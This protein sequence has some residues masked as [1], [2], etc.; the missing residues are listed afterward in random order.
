MNQPTNDILIDY[1][2]RQLSPEETSRI[3]NLIQQ[4]TLVAGEMAYL[5]LAIDTVRLNA[6]Q[7]KVSAVRRS[8][9]SV[10][11]GQKLPEQAIVR[12][13]Y[14]TGLRVA[15]IFVLLLGTAALYKYVSVTNQSVFNKQFTSYELGN[16]RGAETRDAEEEAYRNKDWNEVIAIFN[17]DN[18]KSDKSRFLA[19][20]AEMQL[21]HFAEAEVL[22][23]NLLN[24]PS[25][26]NSFREESEYYISLAY[27][28]DHKEQKAVG[29]LN[30]I[31]ADTSHTYYPLVSK[32]SGI[33]LKII[34][35]KH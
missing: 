1:L 26:D 4:D 6:I 22:F 14:K 12:N 29:M 9:K 19:A 10:Q 32:I 28:M 21:T 8:Q 2:D 3:E 30:K 33:D 23:E 35:L 15:A 17:A 7:E 5:K 20:M 24:S 31:K 25:A 11:F 13:I 27:L 34:E 18:Y 16:T